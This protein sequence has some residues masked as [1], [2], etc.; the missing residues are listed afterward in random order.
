MFAEQLR[1]FRL[2][3][4]NFQLDH[5]K[6][7]Q[8]KAEIQNELTK[9]DLSHQEKLSA[10]SDFTFEQKSSK[11]SGSDE[12]LEILGNISLTSID[13]IVQGKKQPKRV[14]RDK[15]KTTTKS[16]RRLM[17]EVFESSMTESLISES[18]EKSD[19]QC[20]YKCDFRPFDSQLNAFKD[21]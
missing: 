15:A 8:E 5:Q 7:I 13:Y 21:Y 10:G 18:D 14:S 11:D 2:A 9:F 6:W 17:E 16:E 19:Y 3:E 4:K 20:L 12:S 1:K